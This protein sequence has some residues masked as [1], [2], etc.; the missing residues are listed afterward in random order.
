[1]NPKWS[2]VGYGNVKLSCDEGGAMYLNLWENKSFRVYMGEQV[3]VVYL[4]HNHKE[5]C[6]GGWTAKDV[7]DFLDWT[8]QIFSGEANGMP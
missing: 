2:R 8:D 6:L 7:E 3:D 4:L 5:Y 1:M